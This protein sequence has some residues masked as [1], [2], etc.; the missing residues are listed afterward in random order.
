MKRIT[1]SVFAIAVIF[2]ACQSNK[3]TE[4][5]AAES[6]SNEIKPE[7]SVDTAT[8]SSTN[9]SNAELLMGKS[10]CYSCHSIDAK[11]IGP[12][13]NEISKKYENEKDNIGNLVDKI[14]NG[15]SGVWGEVPM[16]AHSQ[17]SKEDATEMVNFI[18][19]IK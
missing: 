4:N 18:L 2:T 1:L 3:P 13:F 16:Q 7:I 8:E 12:S 10:D 19:S 17:I 11:L 15:G 14:I 5:L 6:N 9:K